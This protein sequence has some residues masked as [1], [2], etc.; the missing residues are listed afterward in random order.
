MPGTPDTAVHEIKPDPYFHEAYK[1]ILSR[2][3]LL[4][5]QDAENGDDTCTAKKK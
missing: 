3:Q 5:F 2:C 4:L 1:L